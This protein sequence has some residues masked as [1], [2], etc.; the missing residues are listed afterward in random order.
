MI[1]L[2]LLLSSA[3]AVLSACVGP[4]GVDLSNLQSP[5]GYSFYD[6]K[7]F[8]YK[9]NV[10]APLS[11]Q[12]DFAGD[13]SVCQTYNGGTGQIL[14]SVFASQTITYNPDQKSY[15]FAYSGGDDGRAA[16]IRFS[17][18]PTAKGA[19]TN[20]AVMNTA[21]TYSFFA[22]T[23]RVCGAPAVSNTP[24]PSGSINPNAS[25]SAT[26]GTKVTVSASIS[27]GWIFFIVV[28]VGFVVYMAAGVAIKA[29]RGARGL[30]AIPNVE[31]WRNLPGLVKDGTMFVF[32]GG[33][34][35]PAMASSGS[36]GGQQQYN[37][38]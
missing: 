31:G 14:V 22:S 5:Q 3:H 6:G 20:W 36:G 34:H 16:T 37:S 32:T 1:A 30:E 12:C 18:D 33:K 28:V 17:C 9:F 27:G 24:L 15:T 23:D 13:V 25:A 2:L 35:R 7:K 11:A 29:T 8:L 26:P 19:I 21:L 10:C 38:F 4:N